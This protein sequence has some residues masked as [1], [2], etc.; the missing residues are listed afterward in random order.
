MEDNVVFVGKKNVMNY[1]MAGVTEINKG[2][3][4]IHIKARGRSISTAVDVAQLLVTKFAKG[5]KV[6]GVEIGRDEV[7]SDD[8]NKINVSTIDISINA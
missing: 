4:E 5:S 3:K 7:Q 2:E 8:G 1:V 6:K